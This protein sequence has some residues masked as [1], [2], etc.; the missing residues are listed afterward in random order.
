MS[1]ALAGYLGRHIKQYWSLNQL[2]RGS[3]IPLFTKFEWC[4]SVAVSST[5]F[6]IDFQNSDSQY[7]QNLECPK[8]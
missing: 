2:G 6:K 4:V 5:L 7:I 8:F 3:I 1:P